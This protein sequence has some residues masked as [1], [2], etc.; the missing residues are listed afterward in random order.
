MITGKMAAIQ[1]PTVIETSVRSA[2]AVAEAL[3]LEGFADEGPDHPDAGDLLAQHLVDG[4]E[5]LLHAAGT[6]GSSAR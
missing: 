1:R 2:L 6:R 3:G 4:V 5:A